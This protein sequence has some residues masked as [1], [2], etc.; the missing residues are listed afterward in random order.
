M[1]R[2]TGQPVLRRGRLGA[3][4][5]SLTSAAVAAGLARA[6]YAILSHRPP[7]GAGTWTRTNHR[8]EPV[9]LVEG[10]ALALAAIAAPAIDRGLS[11][12]LRAALAVRK[13]SA[14][15][16]LITAALMLS[17][18]PATGSPGPPLVRTELAISSLA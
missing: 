3:F 12:R 1:T 9:T 5:A 18:W 7:G 2:R 16:P 13:P 17:R 11:P 8:G 14:D 4:A 10:P 6:A 15:S